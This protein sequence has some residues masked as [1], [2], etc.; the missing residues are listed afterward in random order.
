MCPQKLHKGRADCESD[1]LQHKMTMAATLD[2]DTITLT[3]GTSV[4]EILLFGAHVRS[5]RVGGTEQ[6]FVSSASQ[7]APK[8]LRGGVPIW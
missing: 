8:A 3:R 5:W 1:G 7:P 2:A 4:C 6:L